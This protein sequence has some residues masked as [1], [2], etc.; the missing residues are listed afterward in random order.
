MYLTLRLICLGVHTVLVLTGVIEKSER[1][2]DAHEDES[3]SDETYDE[4]R[5]SGA[6]V[7]FRPVPPSRPAIND[8]PVLEDAKTHTDSEECV[9]Y[10]DKKHADISGTKIGA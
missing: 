9:K 2:D 10:F 3:E 1:I 6:E 8:F 7:F 4:Y 5:S